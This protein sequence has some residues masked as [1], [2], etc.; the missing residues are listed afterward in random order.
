MKKSFRLMFIVLAAVAIFAFAC[1]KEENVN[2]DTAVTDT[3]VSSSST[4]ATDT[5]GTM[6]M[7]GTSQT[8]MMSTTGTQGTMGTM[9]NM[10]TTGTSATGG[11]K[12]SEPMK[13]KGSKK[14]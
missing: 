1:K 9:G 4:M 6:G 10:G 11:E 12:K 7:M 3:G 2:T 8:G 14:Y 5:S 13:K